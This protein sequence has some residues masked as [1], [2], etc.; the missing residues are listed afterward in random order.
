[1]IHAESVEEAQE[2][3]EALHDETDYLTWEQIINLCS[4][5]V[6][7]VVVKRLVE[8]CCGTGEELFVIDG[9]LWLLAWSYGH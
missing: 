2:W 7:G 4:D 1:M 5:P 9:E 8:R 6:P 3:I